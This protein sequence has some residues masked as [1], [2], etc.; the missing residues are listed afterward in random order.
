MIVRCQGCAAALEFEADQEQVVCTFC[1]AQNQVGA[2]DEPSGEPSPF[3]GRQPDGRGSG[4]GK[5][6]VL[7]VVLLA[8]G[9]GAVWFLQG[10]WRHLKEFYTSPPC[11][12]DYDADGVT[13]FAGRVGVSGAEATSVSV[14]S[15]KDGTVLWTTEKSYRKYP[16]ILCLSPQH[17]AIAQADLKVEVIPIHQPDRSTSHALSEPVRRYSRRDK[18][19][20]CVTLQL[21]RD[22]RVGIDLATGGQIPCTAPATEKARIS[23]SKSSR[24]R[25]SL[26][27]SSAGQTLKSDPNG[28]F[29]PITTLERP[30]ARYVWGV[31]AGSKKA[32]F[33]RADPKTGAVRYAIQQGSGWS[34]NSVSPLMFNGKYVVLTWGL[35]LHAY[36]PATGARAWHIG[37]R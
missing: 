16:A 25:M 15:G 30:D 6:V 13:D 36:D 4:R 20:G 22:K 31:M 23:L 7:G 21:T 12:V 2:P 1:G 27:K 24:V 8:L 28:T 11:A 5:W 33:V 26:T 34:A 35:G 3:R 14:I 17:V 19:K 29:Y 18:G 9:G 37:G 10:G 32:V